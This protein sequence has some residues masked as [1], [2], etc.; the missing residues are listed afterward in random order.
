MIEAP[1]LSPPE[2]RDAC[3]PKN[4]GKSANRRD[5]QLAGRRSPIRAH[6]GPAPAGHNFTTAGSVRRTL[7][8]FAIGDA[9]PLLPD[10]ADAPVSPFYP[11]R[12]S[13]RRIPIARCEQT[14]QKVALQAFLTGSRYG[15]TISKSPTFLADRPSVGKKSLLL[16]LFRATTG[17]F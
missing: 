16:A 13:E 8:M 1:Y 4:S 17:I 10:S 12:V 11:K 9:L 3:L 6:F 15:T 14:R 7:R 2:L 5:V